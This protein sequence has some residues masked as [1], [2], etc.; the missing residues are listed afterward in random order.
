MIDATLFCEIIETLPTNSFI[1]QEIK[2]GFTFR[3]YS[4]G[5]SIVLV[6][7]DD[8]LFDDE[9]GKFYLKRLGHEDYIEAL[10]PTPKPV[11]KAVASKVLVKEAIEANSCRSCNGTGQVMN[12]E[13]AVCCEVC[14][15]TGDMVQ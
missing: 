6:D 15:G 5:I 13:V 1:R 12:E 11:A 9:L 8:D 10:F 4:G 14:D 2:N 7:C 3:V